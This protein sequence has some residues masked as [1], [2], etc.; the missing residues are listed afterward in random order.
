MAL[1]WRKGY[2]RYKSFFF[3]VY[4]V[5]K[6]RADMKMFLE[7]ILSLVTVAFFASFALRPTA[8]TITQ[9]LQDISAKEETVAQMD[10]KI[11][12]LAAAQKIFEREIKRIELLNQAVPD[13]PTPETFARQLEGL[14]AKH[15]ITFNSL[16]MDD[17]VL[18]GKPPQVFSDRQDIT[19]LPGNAG[20][21]PF[22]LSAI[23]GYSNISTFLTDLENLRRP[24]KI[25]QATMSIAE[26]EAG[27]TLSLAVTGRIPYFLKEDR[28]DQQ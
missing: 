17:I 9:L 10:K 19:D 8:L 6:S 5:Y 25:D 23:G 26:I 24:L 28:K 11:E 21:I 14:A 16:A 13:T 27:K 20:E 18:V 7:I 1:G 15:G 22:S 3:N 2:V 12:G 4:R